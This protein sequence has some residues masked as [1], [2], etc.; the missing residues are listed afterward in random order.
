MT[1]RFALLACPLVLLFALPAGAV[2][3]VA[4]QILKR[5]WLD[6]R[7]VSTVG[8]RGGKSEFSFKADGTLIRTGGR[9]GAAGD[10]KWR[11]DEEGF[12]MTLGANGRESCYVALRGEGGAIRVMRRSG[13]F[14]WTR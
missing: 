9:A 3:L 13:A 6:G 1:I 10:G 7:T 12:C 5:D 4:P 8:P 11:I 2:E 14:T